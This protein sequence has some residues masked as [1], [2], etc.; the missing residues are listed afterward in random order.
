MAGFTH[1]HLHSNFSF[2]SGTAAVEELA[3]AAAAS[4][5]KTLALTDT[6]NMCAAAAFERVCREAGIRPV[7]GAV[8]TGGKRRSVVVLARNNNGY[9][10][11]CRLVT[12]RRLDA[13]FSLTGRVCGLSDDVYLLSDDREINMIMKGRKNLR[14]PL[15]TA[16]GREQDSIRWRLRRE[17][18][19]LG[20]ITVAAG[21]IYFID[22]RDHLIHRVLTAIRTRTTIG[23]LEAGETA[24]PS[25][26]FRSAAEVSRVFADDRRSFDESERIA[27]D[28]RA[29]PG[30]GRRRL[31]RFPLPP[32]ERAASYLRRIA[33]SGLAERL[34]STA[35][36]AEIEKAKETLDYELSVIEGKGLADYF[37]ICWDIVRFAHG[38][39][40]RSVGRGSAGNSLVSYSLGITDL[41]PL[42]HNMF[43][44]RFLNPAREQLPDFDID[45]GTDDRERILE[46]IFRRYGRERVAMIGTYSTLR[47]RS[48]L[49]ESAKALGIPEGEITHL[50]KNIPFYASIEKFDRLSSLSPAGAR[51]DPEKEPLR[52]L[53]P[54]ARRIGGFPRHMATHPC[55]LVISPEPITSLIP[56]QRGDRGYDI[57]QWSMYDVEAAGLVK[58][59]IIGQK[60]L[61]VIC[62]T[63]EMASLNDGKA[64]HRKRIDY[65]NDPAARKIL[66][67]GRTEGCFYIESPIMMQLMRQA[68]C[69][70]FEVLTALSSII[71]P[72]VSNHGGKRAYL[73][74]KLG[75]E[76]AE[77]MHPAVAEVLD[78]THGCLIYQEQVI[79]LA[80]AVAGM[81]YAEADGLRRCMS[82]KNLDKETIAGYRD[83]FIDGALAR[84][85]PADTAEEIFRRISA[86]AGYAFCKAHSASFALE[87]FESAWWKAHYP[88]EFM[89]S[90]IS[91][92]GG[93]YSH[94]EYLEEAKRLG[95][96]ILPPCVN[97]SS[98]RH[99]GKRD[100]LRIGLMQVKGIKKST[101]E[102]IIT[103]APFTSLEDFLARVESSE[104]ET[105]TLIRC[106]AMASFGRSRPQLMWELRLLKAVEKDIPEGLF[107]GS[108]GGAALSDDTV[109]RSE[110]MRSLASRI[111]DIPDYGCKEKIEA[112]RETLD[113]CISGHPLEI[114]EETI[115]RLAGSC[116]LVDSASLAGLEGSEIDIVGWKVTAKTARTAA[117]GE[118]MV[119]VTFSDRLGRFEAVFFPETYRRTAGELIRGRGPFHIRG[120]VESELGVESLIVSDARF[121]KQIESGKGDSTLC[122][123]V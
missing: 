100:R 103:E 92:G 118:E 36:R 58:I 34:G 89:A 117:E 64:L 39:G 30:L 79:R 109:S 91:N 57:T 1:L 88:A 45:F 75:L 32:G 6:D 22:A 96:K 122:L 119:F 90:V 49:R 69:E 104:A 9:G 97:K 41:N 28:C 74:R 98:I 24:P 15:P 82:F 25:A 83:P 116:R 47:A 16:E 87:S 107:A 95:L 101:V 37:L 62:E 65:L 70:D 35:G 110:R 14:I 86:F 105:R 85:I 27:G 12:A 55:G 23:S 13:D 60:G 77:E 21:G 106:G 19:R 63:A 80:V 54:I 94:E 33:S 11:I 3:A 18:E 48:A 78:E 93:Y 108:S 51:L 112:E 8:I 61:A 71:R 26:F 73:Y 10:E 84:G 38:R 43:F 67:E 68:R 20:I 115:S 31:P 40:I 44:E 72:G 81:S 113:L 111:P 102:R 76:P 50:I 53:L 29:D 7:Y 46:Y 42:R 56:L 17:A 52:T 123:P 2:L 99:Y 4:G 114:F 121:L 5:M 59:D 120:R 66:R